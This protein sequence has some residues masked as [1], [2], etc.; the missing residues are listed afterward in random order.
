[1]AYVLVNPDNTVNYIGDE[2]EDWLNLDNVVVHEVPERSTSEV[3]NGIPPEFCVW[4]AE[5]NTVKDQRERPELVKPVNAF[6]DSEEEELA[7]LAA[8]A[9]ARRDSNLRTSDA[10]IAAVDNPHLDVEAWKKYRQELRD[11]PQQPGFPKKISW[12]TPPE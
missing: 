3:I 7:A 9:R 8:A 5:T 4:D 6:F 2:L 12:P 1:M 11:I 10:R